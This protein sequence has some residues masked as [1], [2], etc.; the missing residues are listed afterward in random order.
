MLLAIDVGNSNIVFGI[1]DDKL[2]NTFRLSTN[3]SYTID[4]LGILIYQYLIFSKININEIKAV[5]IA[6]VVPTLIETLKSS[7]K[8]YFS[9]KAFIVGDD[10]KINIK[11]L[12]SNPEQTGVDRLINAVSAIEKYGTPLIIIDLGTTTTIDVINLAGEFMGGVIFPGINILKETL[13]IKTAKLPNIELSKPINIIGK[14][15]QECI[16]SGLYYGYLGAI[17]GILLNIKMESNVKLIATGGLSKYLLE[18]NANID[19]IDETLTLDGLKF[20]YERR[21]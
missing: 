6:S 7:I 3:K 15:T 13:A 5:I 17:E 21:A 8:K 1:Y 20:V 19:Y 9:I 18:N 2:I 11:N 4:E 14:N 16:Q 12:Y 10:I